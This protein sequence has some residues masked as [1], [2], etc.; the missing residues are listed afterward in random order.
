MHIAAVCWARLLLSATL[1]VATGDAAVPATPGAE[2]TAPA[3]I[4]AP[5]STAAIAA[6]DSTIVAPAPDRVVL[7]Y[8]HRSARCNNCLLFEAYTD[9]LVHSAFQPELSESVLEWHVV[10]LD[11]DGNDAFVERYALDGITL[12]STV[13]L[14]GEER[15]FRPLD[16][17]WWL[18][19]DRQAFA[20]YVAAEIEA[21]LEAIHGKHEPEAADSLSLYRELVPEPDGGGVD[22]PPSR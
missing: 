3:D 8:F 17:I 20:D 2:A 13:V 1:V 15:D 22:A 9:S 6:A 14:D 4:V 5:D 18:V 7:Y 16:G 19:D 11:E 12:L 10:N 21:D